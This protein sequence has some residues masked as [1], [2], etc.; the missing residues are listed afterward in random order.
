MRICIFGAGGVGG[1]FG[2]KLAA[3][4]ED[5]TFMARGAHREAMAERGLEVLSALGDLHVQSPRV[6]E[7]PSAA[8]PF[9]LVLVCVKLWDTRAAAEAL[10]GTLAP[11]AAVVSLQNG[12]EAEDLLAGIVGRE[13][14]LGGV[15]YIAS[16]VAR[17]GVIRH[18]G[19]MA[20]LA[21]GELDGAATTRTRA[22]LSI[23]KHAGVEAEVSSDIVG[24][25]WAK[26]VLLAPLAGATCEGRC[27][28]GTVMAD[29]R[30][31]NRFEAMV[32]ETAAVG[33]A[34]G[35]RLDES[36]ERRTVDQVARLPAEMKTSMLH[37][38]EAV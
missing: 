24:K 21:F 31:R 13:R 18:T 1:Y 2:A 23:F 6:V 5:V 12:V 35:V 9:D 17:P 11:E 28:V 16:V 20:G 27:P 4:G 37:D 25:I 8:G 19:R 30:L 22:L 36:L 32:A 33:R 34:L 38:L 26:F 29:P 15:A 3:V 10:T 14:V 7:A